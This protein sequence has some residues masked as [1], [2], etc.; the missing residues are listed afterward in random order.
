MNKAKKLCDC[1]GNIDND[2]DARYC[3][4]CGHKIVEESS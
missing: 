4:Q 2:G 3:K 1:C